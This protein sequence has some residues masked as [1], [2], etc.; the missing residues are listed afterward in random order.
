MS[1]VFEQDIIMG[2]FTH[3]TTYLPNLL[4][5]V[6]KFLPQIP[7]IVQV[8]DL[9]INA[10]F[11]ELR[12]KFSIT[13]KRFW[14]FLDDDIQ[15]LDNEIINIAIKQLITNKW[16]MIGAYSTFN[17]NY[18]LD[19]EP[20]ECK[21]ISWMPGY[22]Q[23]IDS[24]KIGHIQPDLNLP[25]PNTS[26]DTSYSVEIQSQGHKIGICSGIVYHTFKKNTWVNKEVIGITN[27]YLMKKWG[28][29]YFDRCHG[30]FNIKGDY[31]KNDLS[32]QEKTIFVDMAELVKNKY[33]LLE[34]QKKQYARQKQ[35][36]IVRLHLGCGEVKYPG[37]INCDIDGNVDKIF[38]LRKIPYKDN[39]I[40]EICSH[41]AL[42]HI[43]YIDMKNTLK[44][45][46]RVLKFE[47]VL[48]LGIPDLELCC[49]SFCL[50]EEDKKWQCDIQTLYGNQTNEYQFH[51]GGLNLRKLKELLENIGFNIQEIYN[52]DGNNT[53]S[54][55]VLAQKKGDV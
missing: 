26:I 37:Y 5:S 38:D 24:E 29:F 53:P 39:F 11:E 35:E 44:E 21:E 15:F 6:K 28:Q 19:S 27:D 12:K 31:P 9:P 7:F 50:A 3:R 20:L 13:D 55:W 25:D 48:D 52:Y 22:F 14:L 51:K 17:P 32:I 33:R 43:P 45:W 18:K 47:G 4:D 1:L 23:L 36:G 40:D 49:K 30:L 42:E 10:N 8:A 16:A 41:H 2:T 54:V 46:H 34:W